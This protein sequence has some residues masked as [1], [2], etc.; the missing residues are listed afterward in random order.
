MWFEP[1][2]K[3]LQETAFAT[4][5][6][7]NEVL[8][9]SLEALHVAAISIVVGTITIVDLRL[10]GFASMHRSVGAL[11]R[12]VVRFTWV[13]FAFATITGLTL[14]AANAATYGDNAL[15]RAKLFFIGLAGLNMMLFHAW[16]NSRLDKW[17]AGVVPPGRARFAGAA[18]LAL[19]IG[20]VFLGRWVGFTLKQ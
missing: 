10:L 3:Q 9:P 11:V 5:V 20:V 12:G 4:L 13:A 14:F 16:G 1:L 6:R 8:F 7:E 15:F 17:G 19:W 18:S 2:L